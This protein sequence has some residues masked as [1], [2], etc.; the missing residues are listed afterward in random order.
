M[1]ASDGGI[2]DIVGA[3]RMALFF[4]TGE[5]PSEDTRHTCH[6]RDC[7]NA[8]HLIAGSRLENMADM[9]EAGRSLVGERQPN[10]KLTWSMVREAR[11]RHAE[12]EGA[13]QL[14]RDYGI[15]ARAMK[16]ALQ[17]ETWIEPD[18]S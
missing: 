9:R 6:R 7:V 15:S 2:D 14:A 8:N 18:R 12:G 1:I 10:A 13:A 11:R 4:K 17:R 3:H 5:W 16:Q